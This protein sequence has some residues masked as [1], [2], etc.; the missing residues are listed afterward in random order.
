MSAMI[1]PKISVVRKRRT[2]SRKLFF[3][4]GFSSR[5]GSGCGSGSGG[6]GS[7]AGAAGSK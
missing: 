7:K 5:G 4:A 1:N 3:F 6:A 2:P